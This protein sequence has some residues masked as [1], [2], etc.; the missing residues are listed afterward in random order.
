[1]NNQKEFIQFET[2]V[3]KCWKTS[4]DLMALLPKVVVGKSRGSI[5]RYGFFQLLAQECE[6]KIPFRPFGE[7][8]HGWTWDEQPTT[9]IFGFSKLRRN[10]PTVVCN[11]IEQQAMKNEGFSNIHIG[12]LPFA[13]VEK[14]HKSHNP[15]S[16]LAFPPHSSENQHLIN[17]QFEYLDF[18]VSLRNDF[19]EIYVS[20]FGLDWGGD[21]HQAAERRGLKTVFGAHPNDLNSLHRTR[22]L[23]DAFSFVTSNAMGSHFV[24]ALSAGCHFSLCGPKYNYNEELPTASDITENAKNRFLEINSEDYLKPRFGRFYCDH[25]LMGIKDVNFGKSEVGAGNR[26]STHSIRKIL[27]LSSYGQFCGAGR[28]VKN[29]M[30]GGISKILNRNHENLS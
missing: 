30:V 17:Q 2:S 6:I 21:L 26:L 24:Y 3:K 15:H 22:S 7:W 23:L 29:R 20:I 13:Y 9:E 14:Q 8:I 18:L 1:M 27:G 16:L 19:D 10:T 25:P 5:D 11:K 28:G 12:G 4:T